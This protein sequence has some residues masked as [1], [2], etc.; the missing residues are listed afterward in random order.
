MLNRHLKLAL[1][2]SASW[3]AQATAS[4]GELTL[5]AGPG[6]QGREM[7]LRGETRNLT[8]VGFNDRAS[9]MIVR[10]GRWEVCVDADFRNECRVYEPGEYGTLDRMGNGISSAREIGGGR[11]NDDRRGDGRGH[12][13]GHGNQ[14][15]ITLFEGNDMSGRSISLRGDVRNLTQQGFNDRTQSLVVES[16]SWEVCVHR[17]F[18]GQ[19][20]VF[21]PGEYR[22][23][24]RTLNRQITSVRQIGQG[25]GR[26]DDRRDDSN[27]REGVELFSTQGFGGERIQVRDEIRDMNQ[28]NFNDRAGSLIV[29]SGEWVFCQHADFQG[30]C[31]TYGPG[32]YDRLGSLNN[33][34]S[35]IRRVR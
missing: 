29:Y 10:S 24:D 17:D 35:S 11:G 9:S 33:Q 20:R 12:G 30:Q 22:N 34:I 5:F 16:G 1:F 28:A 3:L 27:R 31:M 21:G 8:D 7:T 15:P 13:R 14:E 19:C 26:R 2:L 4:A 23:L 18:G 32:R 25:G 6:F